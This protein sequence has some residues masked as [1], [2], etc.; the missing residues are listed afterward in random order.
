MICI[1]NKVCTK[2]A[3]KISKFKKSY[4]Y[5]VEKQLENYNL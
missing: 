1:Q 4:I 2:I 5:Y 3:A